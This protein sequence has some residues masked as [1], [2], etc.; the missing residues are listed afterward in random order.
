M[1]GP[2]MTGLRTR[3]LGAGL[4][5]VSAFLALRPIGPFERVA[6]VALVP[7]RVAS[8]FAAPARVVHRLRAADRPDAARVE[9]EASLSLRMERAVQLSAWPRRIEIGAG[10]VPVPGEVDARGARSRDR[11]MLRVA[12]PDRVEVGQP[13]VAGDVYVGSVSR[14]PA[15]ERRPDRPSPVERVLRVLRLSSPP[16]IP[17][18][19]IVEIQLVT[20]RDARVGGL[21]V[22]DQDGRPCRLVAGGLAPRSDLVWLAVHNPESRATRSGPVVVQEPLGLVGGSDRM[23]EGFL[24]GDLAAERVRPEDEAFTRL[25]LGIRPLVDFESGL[26]QLLVLTRGRADDASP[27]VATREATPVLGD[28]QWLSARLAVI[29]DAAP[30]RSTGRLDRGKAHGVLRGAAVVDGV[31]LVG[32]VVRSDRIGATVSLLRD[33]GFAVEALAQP[34][35]RPDATPLVLGTLRSLGTDAGGR[36]VLQWRPE[37]SSRHADWI[38]LFG[39][40]E[41]GVDVD[42]WTAS[43]RTRVPRGLRLGRT[44][45]ATAESAAE[46]VLSG[47]GSAA[48]PLRV[49]TVGASLRSAAVPEPGDMPGGEPRGESGVVRAAERPLEGASRA[50]TGRTI[51]E[52]LGRLRAGLR[53]GRDRGRHPALR[54]GLDAA[55]RRRPGVRTARAG[56]RPDDARARRGGRAARAP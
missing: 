9:T 27:F 30:W 35:D 25:V 46:L 17:P 43:G 4:A 54:A 37:S 12:A 47:T 1:G 49:R 11:V 48:A 20:D 40:A 6:D 8:V 22:E 18:P 36:V 13:V 19:D 42:L 15:R 53:L 33:P 21:V 44:R 23:A 3:S 55:C 10:I 7:A 29:G 50:A 41:G 45:L 28:G 31:R 39:D 52:A 5:L 26:N 34:V 56:A 51:V 38:E 16:R 24:L 32:R 2:L 14:I